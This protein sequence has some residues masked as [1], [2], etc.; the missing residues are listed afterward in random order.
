MGFL[1]AGFIARFHSISLDAS[2]EAFERAGVYDPDR[3]R[4]EAFAAASGSPACASEDELLDRSDA[5]YV[6]TWTAEH[7]RLVRAAAER[8]LA[9][10][11]E[12][13][14]AVGVAAAREMTAAVEAAGVTNQVG[15]VLRHSPAFNA[16]RHVVRQPESGRIM[17]I[18]F[19]NDQ[20]IPITGHYRSTWRADV[21]RAGAGA[22]LE[23]SIHDVDML[24]FLA[25]PADGASG[26]TADFH[27][28]PGIEDLAVATLS[29]ASGALATLTSVWHDVW[30]RPSL[31]R[32]EVLCER[33]FV[34]LESDW[35]GP[36]RWSDPDGGE[37]TLEG[38]AL[39]DVGR[40]QL[41][42]PDNP[43]AAFLRAAAAG[44][45]AWPDFAL[46]LRA[47]EVVD[48]VYRSAA[49]GGTPVALDPVIPPGPHSRQ[50]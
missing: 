37:H 38:D 20:F 7:P 8:G 14:L 25:G 17:S 32:L 36:V 13:P 4:A 31:R 45:P 33:R 30:S 50:S 24:E 11:C 29:F 28:N 40:A 47:H 35:F 1:G 46:A 12:K 43:D 10:F 6:C 26:R 27:G 18:V 48:A 5:V 22:L 9:V 16:L 23:H 44:E 42:G 34:V 39:L 3:H 21:A 41:T 19:R 15:L 2:G 49:D